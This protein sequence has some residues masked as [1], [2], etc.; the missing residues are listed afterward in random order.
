[1]TDHDPGISQIHLILALSEHLLSSNDKS[2]PNYD[3]AVWWRHTAVRLAQLVIN[4]SK[5]E[6]ND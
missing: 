4:T 6:P 1:M 5:S 2:A 3:N